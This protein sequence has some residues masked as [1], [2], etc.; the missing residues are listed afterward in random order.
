MNRP[1][2]QLY[3]RIL[4][5]STLCVGAAG[6]DEAPRIAEV[7]LFKNGLGCFT[8]EGRL[9]S[10]QKSARFSPEIAGTHGTYWIHYDP[11]LL[12]IESMTAAMKE[13]SSVRSAGSLAELLQA[14]IG[15]DIE[16]T[17]AQATRRGRIVALLSADGPTILDRRTA[18]T[19]FLPFSGSIVL[20]GDGAEQE[21][22]RVEEINGLRSAGS[23][24]TTCVTREMKPEITLSYEAKVD[25]DFRLTQ[26]SK[27]ITWAPAYELDI[28]GAGEGRIRLQSIVINE[29]ADL[30]NVRMNFISGFPNILFAD[31]VSPF[32]LDQ[33]LSSFLSGLGNMGSSSR[34]N[35][36]VMAQVAMNAY[37][38]FPEAGDAQPD[39]SSTT[40]GA[41]A[42][43]LFFYTLENVTLGKNQRGYYELLNSPVKYEHIY[44]WDI[45]QAEP[46]YS[47]RTRESGSTE[48]VWHKLK[49]HNP[50]SQPLTTAPVIVVSGGKILGQDILSY[51]SP[52]AETRIRITK[53]LDLRADRSE[54]EINRQA[55]ART[56]QGSSYDLVTIEGILSV[57]SHKRED[58]KLEI[59]RSF[60]GQLLEAS[61]GATETKLAEGLRQLN[62][63]TRLDWTIDLPAGQKAEIRYKYKV[64]VR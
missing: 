13:V 25:A 32:S 40:A 44:T 12:K 49:I 21:A 39:Y 8:A 20:L 60:E 38:G 22:I 29:A 59:E 35:V 46:S 34:R 2:R 37:M 15:R 7:S 10:S 30:R 52:K 56:Y 45:A 57:Q 47:P 18:S 63:V 48:E 41:Y 3:F 1:S 16:L 4:I 9:P 61:H 11:L 26:L 58:V 14:N 36:G 23:L 6:A 24:D 42:E 55:N 28:T 64:Y 62:P 31:V 5:A 54:A 50:F 51:T 17:T 43:D 19:S 53:A 27:G 33:E